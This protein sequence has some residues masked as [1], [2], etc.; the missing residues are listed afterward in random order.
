MCLFKKKKT[1][2]SKTN[3][4]SGYEHV[5]DRSW[6]QPASAGLACWNNVHAY[7]SSSKLF[8]DACVDMRV[9]GIRVQNIVVECDN[10]AEMWEWVEAMKH[11]NKV[12]EKIQNLDKSLYKKGPD[13]DTQFLYITTDKKVKDYNVTARDDF[14]VKLWKEG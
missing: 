9:C 5:Y 13:V 14:Y 11:S 3:T 4:K 10:E 6:V 12:I 7:I 8:Y 1:K 2:A